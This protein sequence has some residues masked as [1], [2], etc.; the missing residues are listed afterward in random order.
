MKQSL[1]FYDKSILLLLGAFFTITVSFAQ[2]FDTKPIQ[3]Q[4]QQLSPHSHTEKCA[5]DLILQKMEKDLG[6]FGTKPFFENWI[7]KKIEVQ[8]SQPR[9]FSRLNDERRLIPVVVHIIHSG[10]AVGQG[11][12]IPMEQVQEQIRILN[13]DFN[14]LNADAVNTPA[15][16][17]SVAGSANI[18]F[19]LAKQ[20]PAGLP[21]N[22]VLR[23]QGPKTNYDPDL[24]AT[25]ISTLSRWNPNEYL[26]LYVVSLINPYIGYASFPV[27]DLP[28]LNF[29]VS[30]ALNDGVTIDYR[31]FGIGGSAVSFSRGRTATHEIGHFLG[32]RHIWGDGGCG[33]DDFVEDTP[34]Q[35]NSNNVCNSNPSR[36]SCNSND[37]IQNYMD[38]TPDACMNLFTQGQIER[39]NAVLANSPR[40][41][42]LVN[43]RATQNPELKNNDLAISRVITPTELVCS[44]VISPEIELLNAGKNILTSAEVQL[45]SNGVLIE[46]KVFNFNLNTGMV[47][48]GKFSNITL[49]QNTN[50]LEFRITKV[51][52]QADE[53]PANNI[54]SIRPIL[55]EPVDLPLVTNTSNFQEFWTVENPDESNTWQKTNLTISGVKQDL[56]VLKN[57]EYEAYGQ[58]D[59]L[60]SPSIDLTKYPNAQLVFEMAHGAYND[61]SFEDFLYVAISQDC[62]NIF[63]FASAPY[64]KSGQQ[65]ET[66]EARASEF[67]PNSDDQF[68]T[69]LVNLSDFADLGKIRLAIINENGYGNNIYIRNIRILPN[70]DLNYAIEIDKLISPTPITAGKN[71]KEVLSVKN[72][73]NLTINTFVFS[74]TTNSSTP[75]VYIASGSEIAPQELVSLSVE[76]STI[77]GK[78]K[79]V[80]E[81]HSP[82][83]DQNHDVSSKLTRYTLIDST[84]ITVPWRQDFNDQNNLGLWKTISP[85]ANA[86]AWQTLSVSSGEARN[87]VAVIKNTDA[88]NT[89]WLGSPI[90]DLSSSRQASIFFDIAAG[91]INP[92]TQLKLY[93]SATG[94]GN[95]QV[96]W[97]AS[98]QQLRTVSSPEANPGN[99]NDYIRHYVDLSDFA[100]AGTRN[101][102]LAFVLENGVSSNSPIYLDNIELFLRA[103]PNPVIPSVGMGILYPNPSN[104]YFNLAFNLTEAEDVTIQIISSTGA[105]VQDLVYKNT[106]NQTYTFSTKLF[107]KG[108]YII[109]IKSDTMQ[110][111]KRLLIN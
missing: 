12:N 80:Y 51:N 104:D 28:G 39:F 60:I 29:P 67:V 42:S 23:I 70:A 84:Y 78:N 111:T 95:Y 76:N 103:N 62:G 41:A 72:T 22:G 94:G 27:S 101:V 35:D 3:L 26:N 5:H 83:F 89:Y 19:V 79:L 32:L 46:T 18:E 33:V 53:N 1:R 9:I 75:Q 63:D 109:K 74:R 40:R 20:D 2:V 97:Q 50:E 24:D 77:P 34:E 54:K 31:Y 52:N 69:E 71:L 108:V 98:G 88:G 57:Y 6:Y 30:S 93:A 14:R 100:G 86:S 85:E 8:R 15:E 11:A 66:T 45:R 64:K 99:L 90:F 56:I 36:F 25:M 59:Y 16:F 87:N 106:L 102:R 4:A 91:S 10:Q 81:V 68:R 82:N 49:G 21:T 65:L 37:M 107:S 44:P 92:A 110:E 38:Y 7:D 55:E 61:T 105:I 58:L 13:E 73:G 48:K 17:A 96:V 47:A 43:N